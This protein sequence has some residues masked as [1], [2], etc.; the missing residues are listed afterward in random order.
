MTRKNSKSGT[1]FFTRQ[2][3]K[4]LVAKEGDFFSKEGDFFSEGE[5]F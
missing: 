2:K 3:I 5:D 4:R 1:I